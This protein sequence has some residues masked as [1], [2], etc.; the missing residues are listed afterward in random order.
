MKMDEDNFW[1]LIHLVD[2]HVWD[3]SE[4]DYSPLSSALLNYPPEEFAESYE[5]LAIKTFALDTKRHDAAFSII[6][7]LSDSFLNSRLA[8]GASGKLFYESVLRDP[9]KFPGWSR[10]A[11]FETLMYVSAIA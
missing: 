7:G 1:H 11:W 9:S 6:R 3:D 5:I 10:G 2:V 4:T 8:V